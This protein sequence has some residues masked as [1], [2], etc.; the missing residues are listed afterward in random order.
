MATGE[1]SQAKAL[2]TG[3]KLVGTLFFGVFFLVG[4]GFE[5]LLI[6]QTATNFATYSWRQTEAVIVSSEVAPPLNTE[7]D[8]VMRVSYSYTFD[9]L[10][11]TSNRIDIE[12]AE[13]LPPRSPLCR[14][15]EDT[16]LGEPNRSWRS[17]PSTQELGHGFPS[18]IS[19]RICCCWWDWYLDDLA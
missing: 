10:P 13:R 19:P 3:G 4:L 17:C 11:H 9:G 1:S 15:R 18:S 6:R 7:H 12:T 5:I 2:G 8:P 16:V 14:R